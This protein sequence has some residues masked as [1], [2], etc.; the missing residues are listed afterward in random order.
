MSGGKRVLW[1]CTVGTSTRPGRPS[2]GVQSQLTFSPLLPLTLLLSQLAAKL[3]LQPKKNKNKTVH[4]AFVCDFLVV[5]SAQ[6]N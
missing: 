1:G 2:K 6:T 3:H 5:V 4:T